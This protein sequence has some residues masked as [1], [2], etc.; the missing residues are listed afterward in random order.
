MKFTLQEIEKIREVRTAMDI[1]PDKIRTWWKKRNIAEEIAETVLQHVNKVVKAAHLYWLN[2]PELDLQKMLAMARCH[3]TAEY[4]E[5]D[6]IPQQY[7]WEIS[8]EEKHAR[9]KAVMMELRDFFGEKGQKMFDI[10]ME[11]EACITPEA[12]IVKQLDKLDA[13]V[14]AMEYEKLWYTNVIE[15]Y[16]HAMEHLSDPVLKN[17]LT[18]LLKKEYPYINS[19]DQYYALLKCNGDEMIFKEQM[20]KYTITNT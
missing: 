1:K 4:K 8:L 15:F 14:Q 9:E 20:K 19:Y 13:A 5:E 3:D 11:F 18:I 17:I 7:G 16:P 12:K 6:Y 2:H 10:W